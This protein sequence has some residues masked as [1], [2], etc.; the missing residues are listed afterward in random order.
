MQRNISNAWLASGYMAYNAS[1]AMYE[2][3]NAFVPGTEGAGGE[4][5]PQEG[6]GWTNGVVLYLLNHT[7]TLPFDH[8]T[9]DDAVEDTFSDKNV[10]IFV[11]CFCFA[12]IFCVGVREY[13]RKI[14]LPEYYVRRNRELSSCKPNNAKTVQA[15]RNK[16]IYETVPSEEGYMEETRGRGGTVL[17]S[18]QD[19]SLLSPI[20]KASDSPPRRTPENVNRTPNK[21]PTRSTG[22]GVA[23]FARS[24]TYNAPFAGNVASPMTP[25]AAA[26]QYRFP[27]S[28]TNTPGGDTSLTSQ[29]YRSPQPKFSASQLEDYPGTRDSESTNSTY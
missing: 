21:T 12:L 26:R 22:G 5:V 28:N 27:R 18:V 14:V 17:D 7:L 19:R 3:Y 13:R 2:K 23:V 16:F 1:G 9:A 20:Y 11:L 15:V 10:T 4:Y 29:F 24:N 25:A 8:T 6:F